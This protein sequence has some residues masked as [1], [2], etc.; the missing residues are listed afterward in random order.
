LKLGS[1]IPYS[2][3]ISY[4]PDPSTS[5]LLH[6]LSQWTNSGSSEIRKNCSQLVA[7]DLQL[8]GLLGRDQ[9]LAYRMRPDEEPATVQFSPSSRIYCVQCS[10]SRPLQWLT[11]RNRRAGRVSLRARDSYERRHLQRRCTQYGPV[12]IDG[13]KA[14]AK[15]NDSSHNL[16]PQLL[17]PSNTIKLD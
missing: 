14:G 3:W 5:T 9:F 8:L 13:P 7:H 16:L 10:H 6:L 2:W 17:N 11:A 1:T 4:S 15:L 12:T